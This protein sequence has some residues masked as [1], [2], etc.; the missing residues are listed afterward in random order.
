MDIQEELASH[1]ALLRLCAAVLEQLYPVSV[2]YKIIMHDGRVLWAERVEIVEG[3]TP[4]YRGD[5]RYE[6]D[7]PQD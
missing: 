7:I 6:A 5:G 2:T 1:P 3:R 4:E